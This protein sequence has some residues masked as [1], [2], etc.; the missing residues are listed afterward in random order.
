MTN[1]LK[2]IRVLSIA[3]L[4]TLGTIGCSYDREPDRHVDRRHYHREYREHREG[5]YGYV[6]R[7]L[8]NPEAR[9]DAVVADTPVTDDGDQTSPAR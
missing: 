9:M 4:C 7:E 1:V 2:T 8:M 3:A 5:R 6:G